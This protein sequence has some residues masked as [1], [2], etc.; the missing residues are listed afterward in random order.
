MPRILT[1]ILSAAAL[2]MLAIATP[3][4]EDDFGRN[5][6]VIPEGYSTVDIEVGYQAFTSALES[7]AAGNA[8]KTINMVWLVI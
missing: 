2:L 7:R 6:G 4:C 5:Y 8:I 3:S 1:Y